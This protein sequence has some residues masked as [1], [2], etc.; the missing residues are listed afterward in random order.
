MIWSKY[1]VKIFF[2]D[3]NWIAIISFVILTVRSSQPDGKGGKDSLVDGELS[4]FDEFD[5]F[6][7]NTRKER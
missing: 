7:R 4:T 3:C 1:D 5:K 6:W 2:N